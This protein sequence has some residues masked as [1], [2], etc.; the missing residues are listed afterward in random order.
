MA[1]AKGTS[2]LANL[3]EGAAAAESRQ[4]LK[5]RDED[6]V[7]LKPLETPK[8]EPKPERKD[9][10]NKKRILLHLD[11]ELYDTLKKAADLADRSLERTVRRALRKIADEYRRDNAHPYLD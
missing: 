6:P 7:V 8:P 11:P 9:R 2:A 10:A 3:L 1:R 5:I 4:A